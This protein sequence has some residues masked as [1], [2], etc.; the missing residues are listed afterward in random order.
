[1]LKT[2]P[3]LMFLSS[4]TL[5]IPN[6]WTTE[7]LYPA[8]K[9]PFRID[10]KLYEAQTPEQHLLIFKNEL[11]G[12]VLVLDDII[13]LTEKD[14]PFYPEMMVH[15]PLL[16]HV[17]AQKV[18][19]LGGDDGGVIRE[20]LR[21]KNVKEIT[22]VEIDPDVVEFS[23]KHLPEISQGAF[24]N[25]RLKLI[26]Q[27][28]CKFVQETKEKFDVIICDSTDPIGPGKVLFTN[29]FYKNCHDILESNGIFVN[30]N[31]APF[32][33]QNE[34]IETYNNR[35]SHFQDSGFYLSVIPTY[36]G[37]FMTIGWATDNPEY[38]NVTIQVLEERMHNVEGG[39][40]YYTPEIHK[41]SFALP[42]FIQNTL[43]G[44]YYL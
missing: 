8:W 4:T 35:K 6:E 13:Q 32:L 19:V 29:E 40:K 20:V 22:M 23:K 9:Q 11:F 39:M 28:V 26:I 18:L 17:N 15:V 43:K 16:A 10:E 7:E 1:M 37:G 21:H 14:D 12:K 36:V 3:A 5:A 42:K 33:Q 41:A 25:Q 31:G 44:C 27:D 24:D 38:R 30:Q 2:L 34:L